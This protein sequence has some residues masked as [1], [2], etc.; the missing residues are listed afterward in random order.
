MLEHQYK[1][2]LPDGID[3]LNCKFQMDEGFLIVTCNVDQ[4][5][6]PPC[7]FSWKEVLFTEADGPSHCQLLR[8]GGSG[9]TAASADSKSLKQTHTQDT[10]EE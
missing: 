10:Q 5:A 7:D 4:N 2:V 3:P 1:F 6:Q 9:A 8:D